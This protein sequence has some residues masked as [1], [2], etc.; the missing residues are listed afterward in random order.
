MLEIFVLFVV[1]FIL[2]MMPAFAPPTGI[3]LSYAG[4]RCPLQS[5][6]LLAFVGAIAA[7][8]GR[9]ALVTAVCR[10]DAL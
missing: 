1:L 2:N 9:L 5:I 6:T 10:V 8:M 3:A 4:F 7:T